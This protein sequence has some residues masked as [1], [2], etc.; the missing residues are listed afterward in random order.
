MLASLQT[1]SSQ[2]MTKLDST[3][4]ATAYVGKKKAADHYLK[5]KDSVKIEEKAANDFMAMAIEEQ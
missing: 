4:S 1:E 5:K 2:T 3:S